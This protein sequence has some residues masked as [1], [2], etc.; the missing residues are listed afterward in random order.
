MA[1]GYGQGVGGVGWG[2]RLG[3]DEEGL[4][5][6]GDLFLG[7]ASVGRYEL[8]Y[9][10]R[11]VDGDREAGLRSGEDGYSARFPNS[12][13]GAGVAEKEVFDGDF[14]WS[15]FAD[16]VAYR[17]V[18]A[19]QLLGVRSARRRRDRAEVETTVR[20]TA[21]RDH[22]VAGAGQAGVDAED[23][24]KTRSRHGWTGL[25]RRVLQEHGLREVSV[26]VDL[27]HVFQ[28][29]DDVQQAQG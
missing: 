4:H 29:F 18:D 16:Y 6:E 15:V 23:G 11:L 13:G 9:F 3:E 17:L 24:D 25:P 2:W 28:V 12:Y 20:G 26:G 22:T 27:L 7:A 14:L 10:G 19:D 8:L 21:D 5:H 1:E